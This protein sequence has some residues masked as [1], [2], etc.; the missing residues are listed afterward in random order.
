MTQTIDLTNCDR[1][2]IQFLG[3]IQPEG[4]LVAVSTDWIVQHASANIGTWLGVEADA[5]LGHP[6]VLQVGDEVLHA[7]RGRLQ[8][9]LLNDS[10]ERIFRM[11]VT[12]DGPL[13]DVA[14]HMSGPSIIIEGE[15]SEPGG[16]LDGSSMVRAM[17][18]RLQRASTF[19]DCCREAARQLRML[20]GFDRVMVYRF[21]VDGAGKV[22]A[23]STARGVPS[24]LGL[25][26][27]ASDIPAQ[28]RALYERSWLRCIVDVNAAPSPIVPPAGSQDAPLDL[29]MSVLRSVSPIHC[30]YL[31][32]MGVAASLSVSILRRGK[33]WGLFACHHLAPH[34][35]SLERRTAAELYGQMFSFLL[36]SVERDKEAAYEAD[37]RQLHNRLMALIAENASPMENLAELREEIGRFIRSDGVAIVLGGQIALHGST[38]TQE[39]MLGVIRALNRAH[40]STVFATNEI[41]RV[42]PPGADFA[43]RAAGMLAIPV[44]RKPRDYI[45]FFRKE[46]ARTVTWAGNPDKPVEPGPNGVRLTPRKSFEAWKETVHG[47]STPWSDADL[48]IADSLRV[49]LMEVVLRLSDL[50]DEERRSAR[51]RQELLI[52]ELNHRVRNI[53]AL[54]RALLAQSRSASDTV[55][56]FADI[57]GGRVQA[58]ARA[59]D[60]LT[61]V[62]W[63]PTPLRTIIH[64]EVAAYLGGKADRVRCEG[65]EVLLTPQSFSV[66]ALVLHELVTNAAKYGAFADRSGQADVRWWLEDDGQL[67]LTWRESG[68][69]PVQAP[70]RQ[71][72]GTTIIERSIPHDLKG[73]AEVTYA[74]SG[75]RARFAIPAPHATLA[76]TREAAK[77]QGSHAEVAADVRIDGPVLLLEDNMIIAMSA[78]DLLLKLGAA[79][80]DSVASVRQALMAIQAEVPALALLDVNL[81]DETS[82]PVAERLRE[83]GVPFLFAT[84]YGETSVFPPEFHDAV[85]LRKPYDSEQVRKALA[86]LRRTGCRTG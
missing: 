31:R 50:A 27:P 48:R 86:A 3:S 34:R 11:R 18:G 12:P 70:T 43:M 46:S 35:L 10:V 7:L 2:P 61:A 14:I 81:N 57:V 85:V 49:T 82:F 20:T 9:A 30:E 67:V 37:A 38:P 36:E 39:E 84:G 51:A 58:L 29:S 45:I 69:P 26:Y 41:G 40:A 78:E 74:L 71:G 24:Y 75:L 54:V 22:I 4:F 62:N 83:L 32:N 33:L 59:H 68:G 79:R 6:L 42:H 53:L 1:E 44:S 76:P 25:R 21:D 8:L 19:D 73:E 56:E 28:A 47:Q 72:F 55:E 15:P 52:A 5:M 80:V 13:L 16:D 63:Q 64:A 60:Q 23:E 17:I 66:V 77:P 65:P